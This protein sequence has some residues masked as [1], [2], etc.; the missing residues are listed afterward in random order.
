MTQISPEPAPSQWSAGLP[1]EADFCLLEPDDVP[2]FSEN[3]WFVGYDHDS[4]VGHYLHLGADSTNFAVWIEQIVLAVGSEQLYFHWGYG[5][6]RSPD[7]VAGPR[8]LL[9]NIEP[10]HKWHLSY[11]GPAAPVTLSALK[12]GLV[13]RQSTETEHIVVD[14]DVVTVAPVFLAAAGGERAEPYEGQAF[15]S[16]YEQMYR[17]SGTVTINGHQHSVNGFGLRD[18]S[19]GPRDLTGW[20]THALIGGAFPSGRAFG[21]FVVIGRDGTIRLEEGYL[22]EDGKYRRAVRTEHTPLTDIDATPGEPLIVRLHMEE[23]DV[24][25][26]HGESVSAFILTFKGAA[27]GDPGIDR[28][29][30]DG[31][32]LVEA[33]PRFRWNDEIGGG[34]YERTAMI[35]DVLR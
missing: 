33:F 14:L 9:H 28:L 22:Y 13:S 3:F 18:H 5:G 15:S 7:K 24:V 34:I 32:V 35:K 20:G 26:I 16:H 19:R 11:D 10:F 21:L 23:G 29:E 4:G 8:M 2:M 25:E 12:S 31:T 6:E 30:T 1:P 17:L 27:D